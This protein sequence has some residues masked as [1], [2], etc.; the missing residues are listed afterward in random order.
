MKNSSV[1]FLVFSSGVSLFNFSVELTLLLKLLNTQESL[2]AWL[3]VSA[4]TKKEQQR[5]DN[6]RTL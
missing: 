3:E 6:G 5:N 2:Q 1:T 4:L